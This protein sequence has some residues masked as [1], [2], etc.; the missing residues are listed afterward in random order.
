MKRRQ[1]RYNYEASLTATL[2]RADAERRAFERLD[3][4]HANHPHLRPNPAYPEGQ[5]PP[6]VTE[7][8]RKSHP[9]ADVQ[10]A[11]RLSADEK[12]RGNIMISLDDHL[13]FETRFGLAIATVLAEAY[14]RRYG[15]QH[16]ISTTAWRKW[17]EDYVRVE[18]W[19]KSE[20]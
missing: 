7:M 3:S 2:E 14:G 16:S 12:F 10:I 11:L 20:E 15:L 13:V 8:L 19:P 6:W 9:R 1:T 4:H 17:P 5:M 18:F